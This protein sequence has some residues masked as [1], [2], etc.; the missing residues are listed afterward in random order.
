MYHWTAEDWLAEAFTMVSL[1]RCGYADQ[2]EVAR[3]FGYT[4]RTLRRHQRRYET[5]GMSALARPSWR[6]KGTQAQPS[7]W[8]RT[9]ATLRK[10]GLSVRGIA[11]R[12]KVSVGAVSKWLGR[13]GVSAVPSPNVSPETAG[14]HTS[15]TSLAP[16]VEASATDTANGSARDWS[17]GIDPTNRI[18]DRLLARLGKLNDADPVFAPG[19]RIPHA[20]VLLAIPALVQSGIFSIAEEVYGN[21]GPAFY[22]LRTSMLS[23]S[24]MALL[25]I[26][27]PEGL[28]EHRP[29]DLGRTLGL[30]RAPEVK[31]LRRKLKRLAS[32]GKAEVF[33]R[34]LAQ[35]RVANHGAMMGFLYID[36]QVRVYH[37]RR[38]LPKT[39]STRMRLALP[40]TTDYWV[41]DK[42]GDPVFVVTADVNTAM[43]KMLP[44]LLLKD[45]RGLVGKGRRVTVV[46][47]RAGWSPKLFVKLIKAGFDILT[48]RKGKKKKKDTAQPVQDVPEEDR[49]S[50]GLLRIERQKHSATQ[51]EVAPEADHAP[52]QRWPS[53]LYR[54][55]PH[56]LDGLDAGISDVQA[57][58]AR[59]LLQVP[60]G[61]I[62]AGCP[63][64]LH[65]GA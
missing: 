36:G 60:S 7:P 31:T 43:A 3:V 59:E 39:Y 58:A 8:V 62:R 53:D 32:F 5:G 1:V 44:K 56:G 4:T 52:E 63:G 27:R 6:P 54:N 21:I 16:A 35:K 48:Y 45:V 19:K 18:L 50:Q 28:K 41:N 37:G 15:D 33:G 51:R 49:R 24:L 65:G 64:R 11:Q 23:M 14:Q 55:Q 20:G 26:K 34:K 47:D 22:G 25:R 10:N 40:A 9:A 30:D 2:N 42:K 46:F 12:L 29:P 57:L 61:G 38:K 13:S 17:S